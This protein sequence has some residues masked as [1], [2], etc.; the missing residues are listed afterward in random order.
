MFEEPKVVTEQIVMHARQK[1]LVCEL[2]RL[3][4]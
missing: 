3:W 2:E 4:R 1:I